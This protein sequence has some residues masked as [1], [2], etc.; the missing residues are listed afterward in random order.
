VSKSPLF[1]SSIFWATLAA[2]FIAVGAFFAGPFIDK[3]GNLWSHTPFIIGAVLLGVGVLSVAR[4][5]ILFESHRHVEYHLKG[6]EVCPDP[7]AHRLSHLEAVTAPSTKTLSIFRQ[8]RA[9]LGD[10]DM[11]I[12]E[13]MKTH[14]FW[15]TSKGKRLREEIWHENKPRLQETPGLGAMYASLDKA[16]REIGRLN[17]VNK[18]RL[19]NRVKPEDNL[20]GA[21]SDVAQALRQLDERIATLDE[22]LLS[23]ALSRPVF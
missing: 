2:A 21:Q 12:Q 13:A 20:G 1:D 15:D 7:E 10:D 17:G 8:L 9:E 5:L 23:H 16:Y 6:I 22:E 11:K 4:A 18:A 14:K 3:S 19:P